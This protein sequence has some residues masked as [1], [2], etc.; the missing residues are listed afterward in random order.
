[1]PLRALK[2]RFFVPMRKHKF[3]RWAFNL[4]HY[5]ET[6]TVVSGLPREKKTVL[7]LCSH[8]DDESIGCGG[9][10]ALLCQGGN[11]VDV[12]YLSKGT[13]EESISARACAKILGVR[14][15]TFLEGDEGKL[16]SQTFL[17]DQISATLTIGKYDSIFCPWPFDGHS[18]HSDTFK[19][20]QRALA[21]SSVEA[22]VWLYELTIPLMANRIVPIDG[23]VLL[24]E[25][26]ISAHRPQSNKNASKLAL[27]RNRRRSFLCSEVDFAEAFYFCDRNEVLKLNDM[28]QDPGTDVV[29]YPRQGQS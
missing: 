7:V 24:K 25:K 20:F 8:S 17:T 10:I 19:I 27:A 21:I 29:E 12:V 3:T 28:P 14:N 26:A 23:S 13:N 6:V 2:R 15:T 1:M 22:E 16:L 11:D 18:D 9:T 5:L 4:H